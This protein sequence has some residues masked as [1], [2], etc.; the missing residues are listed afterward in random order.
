M[1]EEN[2]SNVHVLYHS[3]RW[4]VCWYLFKHGHR[5]WSVNFKRYTSLGVE[6]AF[7]VAFGK[8]SLLFTFRPTPLALDS[9]RVPSM[10]G[11]AGGV[12]SP[13]QE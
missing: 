8:G 4:H 13:P 1:R 10:P 6:Y 9:T 5:K 11:H 2:G 12:E 3:P 7:W